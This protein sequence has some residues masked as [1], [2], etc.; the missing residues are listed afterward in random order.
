MRFLISV[1]A[2]AMMAPSALGDT[3][4][5]ALTNAYEH[6]PTLAAARLSARSTDEQRAQARANYLPSIDV[7]GSYGVRDSETNG[8]ANQDIEPASASIVASQALYTGGFRSS[9]GRL[10]RANVEASREALR[11]TEQDVLLSVIAAYVGVRRDEE[12]VRIREANVEVLTRQEEESRARFEVG[13]IT[14]TDVAQ[15]G[16]RLA[17]A[18]SGLLQARADLESSRASYTQLVGKAPDA[19]EAPPPPPDIPRTLD[20]A[21][22]Q[23]LAL[24]PNLRQAQQGQRAA[25]AQTGIERSALLPQLAVVARA[26]RADEA[27]L[28]GV[29]TESTSAAAQLTIPLFEGGYARS[30]VRQSRINEQRAEQL[31]EEA[32][33]A[34]VARVTS[35]WNDYLAAQR[36]V[37]SSRT[38]LQA[39]ELAY[40]GVEAERSVGLRT[41][42]DVLNA[43]QELL[44]SRL[45]LVTAERDS[46]IAQHSLLQTIGRLDGAVLAV[47]APLYD[48]AEHGRAVNRTL[49]STEPADIPLRGRE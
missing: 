4:G 45:L 9:Q 28:P 40:E 34:V 43:Q 10:A 6:N 31:T 25:R 29:E 17:G 20:E 49:L 8:V 27:S 1:A 37:E 24:N 32:R 41:T 48:P 42:L 16:A 11:Q 13:D 18:Q 5:D 3:L 23:A 30:R 26:D 12:V 14:R 38:Q 22:D 44:D 19:L 47:N 2:V 15:S 46:Y 35:S 39:N 36:V 21:V 33:R 7:E